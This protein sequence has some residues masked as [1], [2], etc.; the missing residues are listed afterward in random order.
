MLFMGEEYDEQHPFL[1]FTD[2][3]DPEIAEATRTGRRREFASFTAFSGTDIPDPQDEATFLSSKLDLKAGD[4][5]TLEYYRHLIELRE[6]LRGLPI[7]TRV[8]EIR[9]FL[10]VNRGPIELAMN[11]SDAPVDG[12]DPWSGVVVSS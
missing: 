2:H 5:D 12:V 1:F 4:P 6:E 10:R 8:D 9:R 7:T 3:T 11:F